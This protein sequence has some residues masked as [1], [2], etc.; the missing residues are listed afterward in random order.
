MG[1]GIIAQV[2][3]AHGLCPVHRGSQI[4]YLKIFLQIN[5]FNDIRI[6]LIK[7]TYPAGIQFGKPGLSTHGRYG[8][9]HHMIFVVFQ[10]DPALLIVL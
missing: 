2:I 7:E 1:E 4:R 10:R 3:Y 8:Y 5:R 9:R 6:S